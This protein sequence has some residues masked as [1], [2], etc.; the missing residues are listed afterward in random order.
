MEEEII[1]LRYPREKFLRRAVVGDG[2]LVR[3]GDGDDE[4]AV[5]VEV[6]FEPQD[7]AR[8]LH[9]LARV[10]FGGDFELESISIV[11]YE[12]CVCLWLSEYVCCI[13]LWIN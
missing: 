7:L 3:R 11:G 4:V 1:R 10:P 6:V 13:L 12:I 2:F 8:V 5:G 9:L